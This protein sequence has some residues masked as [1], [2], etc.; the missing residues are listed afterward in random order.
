M[1]SSQACSS[2]SKAETILH[3]RQERMHNSSAHCKLITTTQTAVLTAIQLRTCLRPSSIRRLTHLQ[4]QHTVSSLQQPPALGTHTCD[5]HLQISLRKR[6]TRFVRGVYTHSNLP[7][8]RRN[9][10]SSALP[11]WRSTSLQRS[12]P[13]SLNVTNRWAI[14]TLLPLPSI[15]PPQQQISVGGTAYDPAKV[16]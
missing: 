7:L 6:C 11:P 3:H 10:S 13:K 9:S 16:A 2:L 12:R 14:L 4:I 15:L 1:S 8:R 5:L